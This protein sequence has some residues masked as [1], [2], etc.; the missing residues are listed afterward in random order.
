M[1]GYRLSDYKDFAKNWNLVTVRYRVDTGEFRFVYANPIAW[2]ALSAGAKDYPDGAIF[3][4][5]AYLLEHDGSFPA[6]LVP[7]QVTRYQFMFRNKIKHSETGG[8][9]F[10]LFDSTGHTFPGEPGQVAVACNACHQIAASKGSVFSDALSRDISFSQDKAASFLLKSGAL[11][12]PD[13]KTVGATELPA[14]LKSFLPDGT[15]S[16]RSL[17][18]SLKKNLFDGTLDEIRPFLSAESVA[19]KI[20]AALIN[21]D[22][23]RFSLVYKDDKSTASC[24][25]AAK[26]TPMV[27]VM[28]TIKDPT[29]SIRTYAPRSKNGDVDVRSICVPTPH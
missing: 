28:T 25:D 9:G 29:N 24:G 5:T 1:N 20:P 22:G 21:E 23:K 14:V 27:S 6:S 7:S 12:L 19:S 16:V 10:A 17:Q 26:G 15:R 3:A 8:W 2:R 11:Q 4:K 18:G 13:F